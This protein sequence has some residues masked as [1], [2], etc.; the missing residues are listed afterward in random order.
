MRQSA[1]LVLAVLAIMACGSRTLHA[2]SARR[3]APE[4]PAAPA[5]AAPLSAAAAQLLHLLDLRVDDEAVELGATLMQ[6]H[7]D[8]AA[9]HALQAIALIQYSHRAGEGVQLG[10][11]AAERWPDDPWVQLAHGTAL[12][13]G[14]RA[15]RDGLRTESG[16][17][18]A[19]RARRLAPY[20]EHIA[21][22]VMDIYSL[23]NRR[24]QAVA[25]ADTFIAS[26][27]ATAGIRVARAIALWDM[28]EFGGRPDTAAARAAQQEL[29]RALAE[30]PPSAAAYYV[31]ARRARRD[32]RHADALALAERAMELSP[33]SGDIRLEY[34]AGIGRADIPAAERQAIIHADMDAFLD[35]RQHAVGA[36]L[37]VAEYAGAAGDERL[38]AMRALIQR[39]HPGTWQAARVAIDRALWVRFAAEDEA[40]DGRASVA[41]NRRSSE[42]LRSVLGMPGASRDVLGDAYAWLFLALVQDSATSAEELVTVFERLE[43]LST[44]PRYRMR[45]VS[46]PVALAERGSRLDYAEELARAGSRLVDDV[47]WLAEYSDVTVE[48]YANLLDQ[49]KSEYHSTL[50]WV[51]FHKGALDDAKRELEAAHEALNTAATPLYRLG[52]IAEAQADIE[53]AERWYAAA[54]GREDRER[55]STKAL[56]RLYL[57]RNA[58][59]DGFD[60]Y[61]AAIDERDIQRRRARVE[62]DRIAEPEPLPAFE[63]EWMNGDRFSSESLAGKV[64]VI[65][66]WGVW[67]GPCVREAPDIQKFAGKFSDHPDVVFITVAND[68]D[69]DTTRDFMKGKGYSFPVIL[70]DG[71]GR[72]AK[73]Q[74]Y[75]TTLFVDRDGRIVFSYVG[76][77][78]WLVDEYT[79]R[80]EA[81]LGRTVAGK[82]RP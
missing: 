63:H 80:V 79:W 25:L 8:D 14:G 46:L 70:D 75:P 7:P 59:L 32:R 38:D 65:N 62:A 60:A 52:R 27:R 5:P 4:P 47:E 78:L 20:D 24:Q 67:C 55:R 1:I 3:V 57:S 6:A 37:A 10:I 26:G 11:R 77:S 35:A 30:M 43:E 81:L 56:E 2:Q 42:M 16:L 44:L 49:A 66:F 74:A 69:P 22:R 36:R 61:L 9:L 31:A 58:S 34:W 68:R 21:R 33:H 72:A 12:T 54:R 39:E 23:V 45:H 29:E 82:P 41:A 53:A 48:Q 19:A 71:L 15:F 50:G 73:I 76:A 17:A 51:L 18:A 40:T 64:A 13:H 28:A